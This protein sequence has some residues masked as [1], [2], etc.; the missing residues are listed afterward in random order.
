MDSAQFAD[1]LVALIE[2]DL[3]QDEH[4]NVTGP[5]MVAAVVTRCQSDDFRIS[6]ECLT[7]ELSD[8]TEFHVGVTQTLKR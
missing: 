2:N 4:E 8:G 3:E 5:E 1:I 7:V 6:G